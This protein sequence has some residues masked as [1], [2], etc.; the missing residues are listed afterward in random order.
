MEPTPPSNVIISSHSRGIGYGIIAS[1]LWGSVFVVARYLVEIRG[2][3]PYYTAALRFSF[4]AI[5]ALLYVLVAEGYEKTMAAGRA[6][7]QLIGLGA[8]GIFAM[9]SLV[10]ISAQFT[11]SIN[12]SLIMNS[13]AIF[14]AAFALLIHERVTWVQ[15][16]GLFV[17][18]VGCGIVMIGGTPPQPLPP[19]DN[20]LGC[21]AAVGGALSWAAY[22]VFGK[23]TVRRLG[24]ATTSAWAMVAGA[25]MLASV[26]V[27][28]GGV[29]PLTVI[30]FLA[31]I[32]I[33]LGPSAI[34]MGL[35]Y[36]ALE[37]VDSAVL[38]PSQYIAPIV[39]VLLGWFFLREPLGTG[40]VAGGLLILLGVY[41]AT[42]D[43]TKGAVG[44]REDE[45]GDG[46]EVCSGQT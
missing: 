2:L 10:F 3:D 37:L 23:G 26:A 13:N 45:A 7:A 34:A 32:Y 41:L 36:K 18:L 1:L 40:F 43:G 46:A 19:S 42:K 9:G 25:A 12:S 27:L 22:T 30:E 24:G 6:G 38:G 33:G 39:S 35:W 14:I 4:G 31:V 20:V 11:T 8:L 17:G 21:L 44:G 5:F 29:R 16:L 15:F 28:R